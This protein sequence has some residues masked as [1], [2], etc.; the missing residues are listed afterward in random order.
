M[1]GFID[2]D[3][4]IIKNKRIFLVERKNILNNILFI[5]KNIKDI[6]NIY[7][8]NILEEDVLKMIV[9]FMCKYIV[10]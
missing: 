7:K 5:V 10:N 8:K 2:W 6:N 3:I 1:K 4:V 9:V